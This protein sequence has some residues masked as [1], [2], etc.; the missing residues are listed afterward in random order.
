ML[1]VVEIH[2]SEFADSEY[3]VLQNQGVVTTALR[4]WVVATESLLECPEESPVHFS[5]KMYVFRMEA[6]IKPH[7]H[8][9]LFTGQGEDGWV[10]TNDGR[11]AYCAYWG[12][13]ERVWSEAQNIHMLQLSSTKR[14]PPKK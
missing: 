7:T 10:P 1:K 11:L 12:K 4:G 14:I 8:V 9:V 13:T 5:Q 3:I 6:D 2:T